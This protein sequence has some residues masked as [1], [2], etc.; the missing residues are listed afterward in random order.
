MLKIGQK[1]HLRLRI[2]HWYSSFFYFKYLKYSFKLL[3]FLRPNIEE[4]EIVMP[5]ILQK[6]RLPAIRN[7]SVAVIGEA[8]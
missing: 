4:L 2:K 5:L 6:T 7:P 1:Y 3:V 8:A